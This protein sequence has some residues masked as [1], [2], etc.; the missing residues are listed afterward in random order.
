MFAVLAA[1][2]V[3]S[4]FAMRAQDPAPA[5]R[6]VE[7]ARFT[8]DVLLERETTTETRCTLWVAYPS[9]RG[10]LL[11][12]AQYLA[13]LQL[14]FAARGVAIG[15]MLPRADAKAL[16]A[17]K[18]GFLVAAIEQDNSRDVVPMQAPSM[19][20]L[21]LGAFSM[22][23]RG[24]GG[25][26]LATWPGVDGAVDCLEAF[27]DDRPIS[28]SV[29]EVAEQVTGLLAMVGD[30]GDFGAIAELCKKAWPRSGRAHAAAVL[31][32]W[33]CKGDLEAARRAI[34]DGVKAL[35][36]EAVPMCVF[37]DYVL[38]GDH[39]DPD[40]ARTI[41][42]AMAPA[43]AAAPDGVFTQLVYLRALLRAGQDR[44]AGRVAAKLQKRL[45]GRSVD[46]IVF[47]ET[48]MEG[49]TPAAFRDLAEKAIADAKA[50]GP[51]S[52]W[53]YAAR[54]KVLVRCG[55]LE[56]AKKLMVEYRGSEADANSLNNDAWYLIVRPETMGRFDT[57]A[58]AQCQEMERKEG[59]GMSYGN[60]DTVA[61]AYFVNGDVE[62]AVELETVAEK[63]SN[64]DPE[65]VGRLARYR[66]VLAERERK[67]TA[68]KK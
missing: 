56:A 8:V 23:C 42:V 13:D 48:L 50:A 65:Y 36:T 18:P 25:D 5:P 21:E 2:A 49:S 35:G 57:L 31:F 59:A 43:A 7:T 53:A 64:G 38:R 62:K 22:L 46:Q 20:G 30:G 37:A 66:A 1:V 55:E 19:N 26:Y 41:S 58:L 9:D 34:D 27:L 54:H 29:E 11:D 12:H 44:L 40:I 39:T 68:D 24:T 28:P 60:K 3:V 14:R 45:E 4:T 63:A 15:V 61:L 33:W 47:A 17:R 16:A 51:Y 6:R 67:Q 10:E 52:R 32:Q